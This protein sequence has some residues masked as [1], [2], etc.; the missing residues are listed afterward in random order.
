LNCPNHSPL[1]LIPA[2]V[3]TAGGKKLKVVLQGQR[4]KTMLV[5]KA[6]GLLWHDASIELG[7]REIERETGSWTHG[8]NFFALRCWPHGFHFFCIKILF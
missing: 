7:E 8:Y 1:V 4:G 5:G 3:F 6:S 2:Q